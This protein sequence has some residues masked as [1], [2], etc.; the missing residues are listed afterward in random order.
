MSAEEV[1]F[2]LRQFRSEQLPPLIA[3]DYPERQFSCPCYHF[4]FFLGNVQPWSNMIV[5]KSQFSCSCYQFC[6]FGKS[7][8]MVHVI[9]LENYSHANAFFRE[10]WNPGAA[11]LLCQSSISRLMLMRPSPLCHHLHKFHIHAV[12]WINFILYR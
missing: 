9:V 3:L 6:F 5:L 8:A 10:K 1:A 4:C 12:N 7:V 2:H 11:P